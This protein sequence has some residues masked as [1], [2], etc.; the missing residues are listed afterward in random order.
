MVSAV[1]A[2]SC[3]A[4]LA[5]ACGGSAPSGVA[6]LGTSTAQSGSAS[7]G[8]TH[9]EALAYAGCVRSHG[10]PLWPDPESSG[11]F[12]KSQLTP[13]Q[14]GVG[15][16]K[17]A[18]AQRAC[19]SLLPTYS[20]APQPRVLAQALTFSRCMR[21]HGATGFPDPDSNGAIVIPHAM[22]SSPA[23]L[24]ALNFCVHKYGV[25]PPPPPRDGGG[26]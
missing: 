21:A 18:A 15:S 13:G 25:P 26:S 16:A 20:A 22:E 4:L 2:V 12:D 14:L 24:A 6:Q 3:L 19:K 17:I 23:Y 7:R 10:V 9:E 11:A 8:S 1:L 5:A